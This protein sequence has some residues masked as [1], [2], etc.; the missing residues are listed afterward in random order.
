VL[1]TVGGEEEQFGDRCDGFLRF[2]ERLTQSP[3]ERRAA[4]FTGCYDVYRTLAQC[5]REHAQLGGFSAAVDPF[6][7]DKFSAQNLLILIRSLSFL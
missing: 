6:K 1:G 4:R 5:P 2:E 3:P 7:G